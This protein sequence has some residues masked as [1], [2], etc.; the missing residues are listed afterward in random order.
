MMAKHE[1]SIFT[2][3]VH[4]PTFAVAEEIAVV[5]RCKFA[6]PLAVAVVF[7]A[8]LPY[9]P[10][11]IVIDIALVVLATHAGASRDAAVDEDR[12][13]TH[14]RSTME[15]MVAYLHLIIRHKALAGVGDMQT[16]FAFLSD[17][18]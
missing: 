14:A 6:H 16:L 4:T 12:R 13:Y 1:R 2:A 11:I 3:E 18:V 10:E 8:I 9:L 7:K 17:I 15:E 5:A